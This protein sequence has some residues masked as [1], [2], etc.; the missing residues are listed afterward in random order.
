MTH[1]LSAAAQIDRL[2]A[3]CERGLADPDRLLA[4]LAELTSR[5]AGVGGEGP[6][7]VVWYDPD[8]FSWWGWGWRMK[9]VVRDWIAAGRVL[10][11]RELRR[12]KQRA[13]PLFDAAREAAEC[14][15]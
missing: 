3:A 9:S 8:G 2:L 13:R 15:V 14:L 4:P 6:G 12:L 7:G 11:R 10:D 1:A 5:L